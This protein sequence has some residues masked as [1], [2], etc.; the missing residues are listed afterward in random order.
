MQPYPG[1]HDVRTA[2]AYYFAAARNVAGWPLIAF[3]ATGALA[4]LWKK[5]W[6]PLVLLALPPAF[7]IWSMYGSGTPIF[8]PDRWPNSWYNTRYGIAALPLFAMCAGAIVAI[9]PMRA[10]VPAAILIAAGAFWATPICWKESEVNSTT[11]R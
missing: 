2:V 10:R 5:A 9:L 4:A 11:R 1:D 3:A 6:W 7:F 8:V